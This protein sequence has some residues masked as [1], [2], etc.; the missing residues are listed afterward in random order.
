MSGELKLA[1]FVWDFSVWTISW[2]FDVCCTFFLLRFHCYPLKYVVLSFIFPFKINP[3]FFNLLRLFIWQWLLSTIILW[4]IADLKQGLDRRASFWNGCGSQ[5]R[6]RFVSSSNLLKFDQWNHSG[7][8]L[9]ISLWRFTTFL[10][11]DDCR[12]L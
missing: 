3:A 2:V 12:H 7:A 8:T 1:V 9:P 11:V 10:D 4:S 5:T 6:Y